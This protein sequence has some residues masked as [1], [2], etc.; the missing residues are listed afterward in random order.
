MRIFCM[1]LLM[2]M[3]YGIS[4]L[5]AESDVVIENMNE[6]EIVIEIRIVELEEVRLSGSKSLGEGPNVLPDAQSAA[7][8]GYSVLSAAYGEE[9]LNKQL[10]LR[11][12]QAEGVW[13]VTGTIPAGAVGGVARVELR[14][15][16][17]EVLD[18]T[19][20]L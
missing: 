2:L 12:G 7:I 11:V 5:I 19:H 3:G 10:P 9:N 4:I 17:A 14:S 15:R 8:V 6:D 1:M 18:L 13:V 20:G 16:N